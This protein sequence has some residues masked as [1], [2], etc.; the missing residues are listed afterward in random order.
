MNCN[1]WDV[2]NNYNNNNNEYS[3]LN[4]KNKCTYVYI[5]Q[6]KKENKIECLK[7]M[8]GSTSHI[9]AAIVKTLEVGRC[10]IVQ[11]CWYLS[12]MSTAKH[13]IG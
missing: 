11:V 1:M 5:Q 10:G 6:K 2:V 9:L 3:Y 4:K 12:C 7:K 8:R 13:V